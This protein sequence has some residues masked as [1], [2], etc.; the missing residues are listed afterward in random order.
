MAKIKLKLPWLME[1]EFEI[2]VTKREQ[3]IAWQLY[4]ELG[5]RVGVV[6]FVE[7]E[8][9]IIECLNSWYEFFQFAREK[10][11]SLE[12]KKK[13]FAKNLISIV[14]NLLNDQMRPFLRKWHGQFRHFWE[15]EAD[16]KVNPIERQQTF[17]QYPDLLKEMKE[18]QEKLKQ[19]ASALFKIATSEELES[20]LGTSNST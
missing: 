1:A 3:K 8:D 16:S 12:P 2:N 10:L 11:K 9:L 18:T 20:Y 15:Q 7:T 4:C 17:P 5:T 19:T 6:E 13:K 14:L